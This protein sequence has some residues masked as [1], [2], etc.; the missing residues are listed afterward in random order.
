VVRKKEES[1][2]RDEENREELGRGMGK[3]RRGEKEEGKEGEDL[4]GGERKREGDKGDKE[5]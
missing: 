2:Y 1:R 4:R 5:G 3:R